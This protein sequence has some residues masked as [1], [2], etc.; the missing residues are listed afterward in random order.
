[1]PKKKS[2]SGPEASRP[3]VPGYGIPKSKKGL[4]AWN[5]VDERLAKARNY[6]V[7]TTRPDGRPHAR[8]VWGV[9]VEGAVCFGGGAETRWAR[10]L[11]RNPALVVHLESGDEVVILEGTAEQIS[12]PKHALV[13]R[14][15][16]A[17]QAK[18]KTPHPP[19]FWVLRPRVAFA[20]SKF[21]KNATRWVLGK[22]Q[23]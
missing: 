4:L 3:H 22:Q 14:I 11:A 10:N 6:W 9:W 20:W 17:Y 1:M 13:A 19:P 21:P 7:C 15:Q 5:F 18:Y 2:P 16:E 23:G 12:D 8:A